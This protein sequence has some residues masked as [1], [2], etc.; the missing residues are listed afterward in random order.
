VRIAAAYL[1]Q[2]ACVPLWVALL[3]ALELC[4]FEW[5]DPRRK[6]A[7]QPLQRK[8]IERDGCRCTVPGCT[9]RRNLQVNHIRARSHGGPDEE[10]NLHAV[11]AAHHLHY[12]HGGLARVRGRAPGDMVW[13]LGRSELAQWFVNDRRIRTMI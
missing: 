8:V 5:D 2:S 4:A 12:I 1:E 7:S 11:C 3:A 10:W 13:R 9:A 6:T